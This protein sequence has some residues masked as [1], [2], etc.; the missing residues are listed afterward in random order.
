LIERNMPGAE[1]FKGAELNYAEHVFR[2]KSSKHPALIFQSE[3]QPLMEISWDEFHQKVASIASALR[4]MGI[5]RGDRVVAYMPNIPQTIMA[6]LACASIGATWSSCS[7]DFGTRS[8]VDRFKQIEPKVL[9]VVDGYQYGGK[10]FDCHPAIAELQQSLP[11]LERTV[12]V[13][14]LQPAAGS[15]KL[16]NT[17]ILGGRSCRACF[18]GFF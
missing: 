5:Q 2:S 4:S 14:Y 3:I 1:W 11:T 6:F 12:L 17:V 7:P 10:G 8:V 13:P 16:A 9:F 18:R 15:G